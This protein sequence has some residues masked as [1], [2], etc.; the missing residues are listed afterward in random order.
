MVPMAP[1]VLSMRCLILTIMSQL[2]DIA[3]ATATEHSLA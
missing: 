1:M 3:R 2:I